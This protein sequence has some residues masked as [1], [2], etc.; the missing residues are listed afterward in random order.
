MWWIRS[1]L[2]ILHPKMPSVIGKC[3]EEKL[4]NSGTDTITVTPSG[5]CL[6]TTDTAVLG[7]IHGKSRLEVNLKRIDP[8]GIFRPS[9]TFLPIRDFPLF[10]HAPAKNITCMKQ[11]K[12][13]KKKTFEMKGSRN[14]N[15]NEKRE[16]SMSSVW[17]MQ[18]FSTRPLFCTLTRERD[19]PR[20]PKGD[21]LFEPLIFLFILL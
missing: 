17:L 20:E 1:K 2:V 21:D 10:L 18:L 3:R 11:F 15:R 14:E 4:Q 9:F 6:L 13:K 5:K 7:W 19:E 8:C 16:V 12:W